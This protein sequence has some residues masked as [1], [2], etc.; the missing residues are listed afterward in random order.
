MCGLPLFPE[1]ERVLLT[2][3]VPN[4]VEDLRVYESA[5]LDVAKGEGIDLR[6]KLGLAT[7]EISEEILDFLLDQGR[8]A[9]PKR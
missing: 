3:G 6:T 8:G 1:E 9:D 5:I 4:T 7:E 2:D